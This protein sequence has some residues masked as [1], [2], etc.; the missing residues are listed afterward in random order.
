MRTPALAILL[1]LATAQPVFA[2]APTPPAPV[3]IPTLSEPDRAKADAL[4]IAA[5]THLL[6]N[7][8]TEAAPL[9][10]EAIAI[11]APPG[12]NAAL[13][14]DERFDVFKR[15]IDARSAAMEARD[16]GGFAYWAWLIAADRLLNVAESRGV[17]G[18]DPITA[19]TFDDIYYMAYGYALAGDAPRFR[20][21][22]APFLA[23]A[24]PD[25]EIAFAKDIAQRSM[26]MRNWGG[27]R[28]PMAEAMATLGL[29]VFDR[30]GGRAAEPVRSMWNLLASMRKT[31]G[32]LA[33]ARAAYAK[34]RVPGAPLG[35]AEIALMFDA[36]ETA[37]A[38]AAVRARFKL[39]PTA[40]W[41]LAASDALI[42]IGG[43]TGNGQVGTI[44]IY[45]IA[46]DSYRRLLK[47][48]DRKLESA[49]SVLARAYLDSGDPQASEAVLIPLLASAE[50]RWGRDSNG[51]IDYAVSLAAAIEAQSRFEEAELIYRRVWD[52]SVKYDS[53]D[54]EDSRR[55]FAGISRILLARAL[56]EAALAFTADGIARVRAAK[57]VNAWRRMYYLLSRA[58][59][60]DA[61]GA[62]AEAESVVREAVALGDPDDKLNAVAGF[63]DPNID[64]RDRLAGLL[65]KQGKAAA[66]EPIRRLILSSIEKQDMIPWEGEVRTEALRALAANLTLQGKEEGARLF[67]ARIAAAARIYGTDS[68]QLL[69]V[70]EPFARALLQSGRA[71]AALAPA[72]VALAARTSARFT[73]DAARGSARDLALSRKRTEAARLMVEAAWKASR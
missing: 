50:K 30:P 11:V 22:A 63:N 41:S 15:W 35:D 68:P 21:F 28:K 65:E 31:S 60:L 37:A 69:E 18:P 49:G 19:E 48:G 27:E 51:A 12:D 33:G 14:G 54:G 23:A 42:D 4:L 52:L 25:A 73:G 13:Q 29:A 39:A 38:I 53:F 56:N 7:R 8:R 61:T 1:L 40:P 9:L 10:R 34:G 47:P 70:A 43:A 66:A 44:A 57:D 72:R 45:R 64:S 24:R 2:Q 55:A 16:Y 62:V 67:T 59:V 26:S 58:Q 71:G 5:L 17:Y 36:G 3:A 32:D 46:Y 20:Q 6:A